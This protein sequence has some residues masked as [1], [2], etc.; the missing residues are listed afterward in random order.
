MANTFATVPICPH[1]PAVPIT[2]VAPRCTCLSCPCQTGG[3]CHYGTHRLETIATLCEDLEK[4]EAIL[5]DETEKTK[6]AAL[7]VKRLDEQAKKIKEQIEVLEKEK[8]KVQIALA[9]TAENFN[10]GKVVIAN[11]NREI[12]NIRNKIN[13]RTNVQTANP[14]L[15][16]AIEEFLKEEDPKN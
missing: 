8:Q 12:V 11:T 5:A 15:F 3:A 9:A 4:Q 16:Q 2:L 14:A 7:R 10:K 6:Q 1:A 13:A